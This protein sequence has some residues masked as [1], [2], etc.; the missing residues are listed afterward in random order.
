MATTR[1]FNTIIDLE[2]VDSLKLWSNVVW[3]DISAKWQSVPHCDSDFA[4]PNP[5]PIHPFYPS[6]LATPS[7]LV[8][9]RLTS[10]LT[11]VS[12]P[13]LALYHHQNHN[14]DRDLRSR[15]R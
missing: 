5:R 15:T 6:I 14:H 2:E 10:N 8:P 4:T 3:Y 12:D 1:Q 9:L 11:I 13:P 7:A